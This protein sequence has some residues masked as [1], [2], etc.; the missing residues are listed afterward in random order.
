MAQ[1]AHRTLLQVDQMFHPRIHGILTGIFYNIPIDIIT[2][3]IHIDIVAYQIIGF[4][5][6]LIPVFHRQNIFPRF[7]S[8]LTIHP[9]CNIGSDHCGFNREGSAAAERVHQNPVSV[10]RR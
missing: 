2:L 4:G 10:P 5:N 1:G 7:R 6:R 3:N 9:R 8:E